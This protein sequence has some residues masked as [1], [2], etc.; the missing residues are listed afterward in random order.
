MYYKFPACIINRWKAAKSEG[1]IARGN[2]NFN[3][4]FVIC[5]HEYLRFK[6]ALMTHI[7]R[8]KDRAYKIRN[9]R[10]GLS[11]NSLQACQYNRNVGLV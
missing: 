2:V 9:C 3:V 7:L 5:E 1:N 6:S 4:S 11:L 8:I 10:D